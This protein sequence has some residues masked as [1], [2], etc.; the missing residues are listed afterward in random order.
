M[1]EDLRYAARSVVRARGLTA[2]LI[3]SLALGTGANAA[4]FGIVYR[5]LLS[6]PDGVEGAGTLVSV[7][8][9]E[10][11]GAPYGRSSY[12]DFL[13][14]AALAPLESVA[15][16]DDNTSANVAHGDVVRR[17]R[18]VA[19]S[20]H[21][22][23]LVGMRPHAG[24]LLETADGTTEPRGAVISLALAEAFDGAAAI[25]GRTIA[26]GAD[27]YV[28]V[29]VAPPKFRGLQA[30]RPSDVW[31]PLPA[32]DEA[33]RGD[34]RLSLVARRRGPL[35][36]VQG[37]LQALSAELAR[38]Y[39]ETNQ[40]SLID[41]AAPRQLTAIDYSPLD[42]DARSE[43][44]IVAAVVVGAVALLL[45]SACVNAGT[46][47][48][49]RAMAR[50]HEVAVKMAL[51]AG[52]GT[53]MRQ[54]L[55]E[56]LIVSLGGGALGLVFAGWLMSAIP[57][58]F[59]P[60]QA[61]LLDT[62]IDA[63]LVLLT[64]GIAV[65]AGALFGIAPAIHGT[66][67]PAALAL[68]ADP[69]GVSDESGGTRMRGALITAQ[70]ALSTVL[71]VAT[72]LLLTGLS[73]AL[74]GDFGVRSANVAML[75]MQN[76]GGNCNIYN[77]ILGVRFHNAMAE[78]LP[79]TP[80]I[81]S[82]GWA[83]VPPLGRGNVR[84][85]AVQAGARALDRVDFNVVVV[86]PTYF[87]TM[88]MS[89]VEG[90]LF[91]AGDGAL[92][93]AVAVVDD[94]LARRHFGAS[95]VG[96]RL[97]NGRGEPV[98]I[99]GVVRSGRYR[100]LQDSPQPTVYLPYAQEHLPCGYLF[101]RTAGDPAAMIPAISGKLTG[102]DRGV[103]ITRATTLQTHLA[104]ALT[105]DR[106]TTTLVGLCGIIALIMGTAGVYGV[107]SDAVRRR[108]REIGLRV[109]LGAGRPQVVRLV[110]TE[111]LY[112][113]AAGV[114][115]GIIGALAVERLAES[116]VHGLP[117]VDRTTLAATPAI[118]AAVVVLAAILPLRRALAVNPTVAL[119]AE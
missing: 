58:L 27:R 8:T 110:F 71:L 93:G 63:A 108:T 64:V 87:K 35:T 83:S 74:N 46:L 77:P 78:A 82:A 50:R 1:F 34:R 39:P 26:V 116:V 33:D 113:T 37:Q 84:Q 40:G 49:S 41:P 36:E 47:L 96:Q 119:R 59:A 76:P 99:V 91:D 38:R 97:L 31:V 6:A 24:R 117:G 14:L 16:F 98:K 23:S 30:S 112:L 53:L 88:G 66:G 70:L 52:R 106:L 13:A 44:T 115:L 100:T 28:V 5:L 62:N 20:G 107:M 92:A 21:F 103:T 17:G 10:F 81:S 61:V 56:S 18:I 111:A 2:V 22:F 68:R 48:L 25:V 72:G 45:A 89:L 19:V 32:D 54:L 57:A 29:G 42:P 43:A 11:S 79:K 90:R 109:A 55:F 3:L 118:L 85:Y 12:P 86:S 101:V 51:G 102:I 94:L 105:I 69:G 60:D 114:A 104:E 73:Q 67:S 80:G 15:A 7:Y 95:A 9:S 65:A 75:A 4:V